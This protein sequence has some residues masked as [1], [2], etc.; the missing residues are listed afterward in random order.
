MILGANFLARYA[1]LVVNPCS[2][3]LSHARS[4]HVLAEKVEG[5]ETLV[6]NGDPS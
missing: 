6:V 3:I 4:G 1:K 5:G 2:I